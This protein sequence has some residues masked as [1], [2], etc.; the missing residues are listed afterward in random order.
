MPCP[1]N[2]FQSL[3]IDL[4]TAVNALT[5][6]AFANAQ[7]G[8]IHHLQELSLIVALS[9]EKFLGVGARS[10]IRDVLCGIFIRGSAV[11]LRASYGAPQILL[12][13]LQPFL[14]AFQL[15]FVHRS[16]QKL[17]IELSLQNLR[18]TLR[19]KGSPPS[20]IKR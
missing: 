6:A 20:N 17:V 9:K 7:Q 2:G 5:E 18:R 14:K 12:P 19:I 16:L 1:G 8:V 10:T 13:R 3:G 4:L 11:L 15:L